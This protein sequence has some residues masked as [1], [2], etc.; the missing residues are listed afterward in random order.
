MKKYL[1]LLMVVAMFAGCSKKS[2]YK[3]VKEQAVMSNREANKRIKN[4]HKV[5]RMDKRKCPEVK[6]SRREKRLNKK[7]SKKAKQPEKPEAE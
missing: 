7:E 6:K 2:G 3:S 5:P 1:I 4:R